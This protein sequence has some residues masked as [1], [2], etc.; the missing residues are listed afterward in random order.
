[1]SPTSVT[2]TIIPSIAPNKEPL[3]SIL[4]SLSTSSLSNGAPT[5]GFAVLDG[6]FS[7][8]FLIRVYTENDN[9]YTVPCWKT[10][11]VLLIV[12]KLKRSGSKLTSKAF[13]PQWEALN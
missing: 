10:Y 2:S 3:I 13:V 1:M 5:Y 4:P 12:P 7:N 11:S 8:L 9:F 6:V